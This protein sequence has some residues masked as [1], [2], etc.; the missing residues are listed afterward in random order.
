MKTLYLVLWL[1]GITF[2]LTS[3]SFKTAM[4]LYAGG[5]KTWEKLFVIAIY[6]LIFFFVTLVVKSFLKLINF[7]LKNSVVI[8]LFIAVGLI[9]WGI[10]L[11]RRKGEIEKKH[12]VILLVPCPVCLSA[13]AFSSFLFVKA[14]NLPAW[15]SGIILAG[16]FTLM[17]LSFYIASAIIFKKFPFGLY[18]TLLGI[19]MIAIGVYLAGAFYFPAKIELAKRMYRT[20]STHSFG[21]NHANLGYILLLLLCPVIAGALFKRRKV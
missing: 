3:F 13:M 16:I 18:Q 19:F 8:H 10:Y 20:F 2:S 9:L 14:V 4:A 15:I 21:V 6:D 5:F 12:A 7:L 1:I 11:I 17:T